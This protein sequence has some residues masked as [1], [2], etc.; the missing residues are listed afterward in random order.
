MKRLAG[1][2]LG[3]G[4]RLWEQGTEVHFCIPKLLSESCWAETSC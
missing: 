2:L 1:N 4:A 3:T